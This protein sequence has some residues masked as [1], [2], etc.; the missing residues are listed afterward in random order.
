MSTTR[1]RPSAELYMDYEEGMSRIEELFTAI[2][3]LT[4]SGCGPD[5]IASLASLG[6]AI[7]RDQVT[8]AQEEARKEREEERKRRTKTA[9]SGA[10]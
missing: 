8:G 1:Y 6:H 10:V 7:T 2:D 9:P 4:S 3:Y 5:T